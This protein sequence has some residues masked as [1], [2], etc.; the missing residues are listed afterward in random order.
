MTYSQ[1][2]FTLP[3]GGRI[4]II[5]TCDFVTYEMPQENGEL[6]RA[7]ILFFEN[8]A[9]REVWCGG[10]AVNPDA[11]WMAQVARNQT[12][13]FSGK[14][15]N[16]RYLIHDGDPLFKARFPD[17]LSDIGCKSKRIP[18]RCPEANGYVESFIKTFK[19][20]CLN[21]LIITSVEQLRYVVSEFLLYYNH[22][23]PHSG[24]GGKLIAPWPQPTHGEIRCFSR[25][26]GLLKSYR[27]VA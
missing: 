20:E 10:I 7:Q 14:L 25:L 26:G 2:I 13:C 27:R 1:E 8:L 19:T 21:H 17:Y 22:E 16:F 6:Q 11:Q 4:L 3:L 9:T 12:D 18:P 5:V 15:L 24:L 23:R